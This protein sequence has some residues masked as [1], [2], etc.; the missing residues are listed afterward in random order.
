MGIFH[1]LKVGFKRLVN[2]NSIDY[3]PEIK[4][5]GNVAELNL[6]QIIKDKIPECQ[7]KNNVI[8]SLPDEKNQA[9]IDCLVLLK[10]KLFAIEIK[11]WR[12][13]IVEREDG[14]HSYKQDRW[15]D[16]LWEKVL[17]SPFRQINRAV[18]LLKKQT[19][20][21]NWVQS[22]VFFAGASSVTVY[23]NGV[24]F[25]N[26]D[27]LIQYMIKYK[28]RYNS[29][30]NVN[31][32]NFAVAADYVY[33]NYYRNKRCIID[34]RSLCFNIDGTQLSRANILKINIDHHFSY[35]LLNIYLKDGSVKKCKIE[36]GEII[37]NDNNV[38]KIYSLCKIQTICLG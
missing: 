8:I 11:H 3:T 30:E 37:V 29:Q 26:V 27:N 1:K 19:N 7:I 9:E 28:N 32:F 18:S 15:T 10:D 4:R 35:D 33:S 20:N 14:F 13:Y 16:D 31:C 5:Y 6:S 2:S 34:D 21:Y 12:G 38:R 24:W 25:D 23:D 17:K 22:I 36:D